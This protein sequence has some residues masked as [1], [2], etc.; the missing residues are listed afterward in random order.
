MQYGLSE[1]RTF[2]IT[3]G[4]L[5]LDVLTHSTA[6]HGSTSQTMLWGILP[7]ELVGG[8]ALSSF[9]RSDPKTYRVKAQQESA[10]YCTRAAS[11]DSFQEQN[12]GTE[13]QSERALLPYVECILLL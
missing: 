13:R 2:S 4:M 9:C 8:Q 1:S 11:R 12:W 7:E 6:Q 10:G 5:A 3:P